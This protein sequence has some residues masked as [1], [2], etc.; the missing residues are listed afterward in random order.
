MNVPRTVPILGLLLG[1][2]ALLRALLLLDRDPLIAVLGLL[3]AMAVL[4][5]S[6]AVLCGDDAMKTTAATEDRNRF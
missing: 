4:L 5:A 6:T 3:A 2:A 1:F